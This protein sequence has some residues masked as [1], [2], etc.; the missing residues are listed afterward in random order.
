[1][2]AMAATT[3]GPGR[4]LAP[5]LSGLLQ[6]RLSQLP[7]IGLPTLP[8]NILPELPL[9]VA[10]LSGAVLSQLNVTQL[11]PHQTAVSQV[12]AGLPVV[13]GVVPHS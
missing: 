5:A 4:A 9:P 12:T 6:R 2:V 1:M 11:D 13:L 8:A 10:Q 3:R 7:A